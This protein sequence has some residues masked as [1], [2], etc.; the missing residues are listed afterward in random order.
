MKETS[1]HKF[2]STVESQEFIMAQFS[3]ILWGTPPPEINTP[4][5]L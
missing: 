1:A 2:L 3:W 4:N 5:N